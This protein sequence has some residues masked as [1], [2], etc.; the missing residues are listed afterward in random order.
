[1]NIT[2]LATSLASSKLPASFA[3]FNFAS[4]QSARSALMTGPGESSQR[5]CRT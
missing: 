1:M 3:S 5:G 4:G 2:T